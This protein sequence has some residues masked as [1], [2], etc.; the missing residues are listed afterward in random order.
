M[1]FVILSHHRAGSYCWLVPILSRVTQM[2]V[3]DIRDGFA[4]EANHVYVLPAGLDVT[5]DGSAFH[6]APAT[7]LRGWPDA[8][9]IFLR[10]VARTTRFRAI[11]V[12]LSGLAEDGSAAMNELQRG[13]GVNYAQANAPYAS[14][15]RSAIRTGCVD[16][17]G[18]ASEIAAAILHL[19][20]NS[21]LTIVA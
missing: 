16:Y 19:S 18:S 9:D 1:V 13:G 14:I 2:H 17:V 5:T 12:I 20:P 3:E 8:F 15:P 7:K 6:P 10:S 11:T 4:F 21:L